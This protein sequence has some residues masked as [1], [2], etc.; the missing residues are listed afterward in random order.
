MEWLL[1]A[2]TALVFFNIAASI[3]AAWRG[4]P[5]VVLW[6]RLHDKYQ[7]NYVLSV[8][9]AVIVLF[10]AAFIFHKSTVMRLI[11]AAVDI[12]LVYFAARDFKKWSSKW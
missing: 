7:D 9:I 1:I 8:V 12:A 5:E 3:V 2:F 6:N 11:V 10:A 4:M